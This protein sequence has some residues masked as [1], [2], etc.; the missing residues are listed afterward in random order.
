MNSIDNI[1][2]EPIGKCIYC[3]SSE[4]LSREHIIPL[5]LSGTAVLPKSTC[6]ECAKI[7]GQIEQEVLRGPLRAVRLYREL[8]SRRKHK[9]APKAYP[10]AVFKDGRKQQVNVPIVDYPILLHFPIFE[11]AAYLNPKGYKRGIS[12]SGVDTISFGPAPEAVAQ[13]LGVDKKGWKDVLTTSEI[14]QLLIATGTSTNS[15]TIREGIKWLLNQ[16]DKVN[17]LWNDEI[18]DTSSALMALKI[19]GYGISNDFVRKGLEGLLNEY[20]KINHCW[21][22][23]WETSMAI[24][25]LK[26]FEVEKDIMLDATNWILEKRYSYPLNNWINLHTTALVLETLFKTGYQWGS[27]VRVKEAKNWLEEEF[28]KRRS[29]IDIWSLALSMRALNCYSNTENDIEIIKS[30]IREQIIPSI[31][32]GKLD[33][34]DLCQI[35]MTLI[36]CAPTIMEPHMINELLDFVRKNRTEFARLVVDLTWYQKVGDVI[37]RREE[38]KIKPY[39]FTFGLTKRQLEILGLIAALVTISGFVLRLTILK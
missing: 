14:I 16:Q 17:G 6:Q 32:K 2:Y 39:V 12:L 19:A 7:T 9:D 34:V 30:T 25:C 11:P 33:V 4:D 29:D 21:W 8:R 26:A 28:K 13:S 5:G 31:E 18:W 36:Q 35:T 38:K 24:Q 27:D 37:R 3:G 23:I 10:L 22:D 15:I 1:A 20:D